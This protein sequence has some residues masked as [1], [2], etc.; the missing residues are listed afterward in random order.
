LLIYTK[1]DLSNIKKAKYLLVKNHCVAIHTETVYGLA[2]NAYYDTA[3]LKIFKLKK[4]HKSNSVIVHYCKAE[5]IKNDCELNSR[6]IKLY[7]KFCL[8]T[9][10]FFFKIKKK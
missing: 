2:A 9:F 7:N 5:D 6:F 10:N 4:R 3:I 1:K 8:W